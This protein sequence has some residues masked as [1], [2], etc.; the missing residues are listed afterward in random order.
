MAEPSGAAAVAGALRARIVRRAAVVAIVSGGNVDPGGVRER[1]SHAQVKPALHELVDRLAASESPRFLDR[2][3]DV[4]D[5]AVELLL[6][7]LLQDLADARA[8]RA[9]RARAGDGRA[10]AAPAADARRRARARARGTSPSP[11]SRSR[12][13]G[14]DSRRARGAPAAR[15]RPSAPDGGT[16]RRRRSAPCGTCPASGDC[17]TRPTPGRARR[18][19]RSC[20]RS[21]DRAALSVGSTPACS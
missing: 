19:R 10:A 5:L 18:S 7:D 2:L 21:A 6:V 14:R 12:R 11:S 8:R 13:C 16:R 1:T 17:A 4:R 9:R 20:A 3:V 15:G